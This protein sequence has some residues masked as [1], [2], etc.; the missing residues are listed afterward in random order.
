[1]ISKY[2]N[3]INENKNNN[4]ENKII[5]SIEFEEIL[6]K[7]NNEYNLKISDELIKLNN[8][9]LFKYSYI[10]ISKDNENIITFIYNKDINNINNV[11]NSNK[12]KKIKIGKFINRI[13]DEHYSE[14]DIENFINYYRSIIREKYKVKFKLY[15]GNDIKKWYNQKNNIN[16]GIL[17]QSCMRYDRCM[18]YLNLYINNPEKISLLVLFDKK[19][20]TKII[21]RS[22][23]WNL[24]NNQHMMDMI[25][26]SYD[27]DISI[28]KRYA[29]ENNIIIVNSK[30]PVYTILKPVDYT[31]FPYLDNMDL[32]QP[33]TGIIANSINCFNDI[34][35]IYILDDTFGSKRKPIFKK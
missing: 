30:N 15:N 21:G 9:K 31:Y 16:L 24:N 17:G 3:F 1:M 34:K 29:K 19:D 27:C 26:T 35:D 28:F 8:K 23:I 32:Y 4:I 33:K 10:D 2:L 14:Y 5:Y 11:W 7:I 22:L 12:R 6:N 13:I 20:Y 18:N 25:Y